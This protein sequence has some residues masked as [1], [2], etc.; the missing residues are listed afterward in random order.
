[1]RRSAARRCSCAD[2]NEM[3]EITIEVMPLRAAGFGIVKRFLVLF[4]DTR[5]RRRARGAHAPPIAGAADGRLRHRKK[6]HGLR[7][8]WAVTRS[9]CSRSSNSSPPPTRNSNPP[10][11]RSSPPTRS[12]RAPTRNCRPPRKSCRVHQRGTR[13]RQR[14]TPGPQRG[15]QPEQRRP[16]QP[17]GQHED[18]HRDARA[19]PAHPPLH[20]RGRQGPG[21][22]PH[23]PG[24]PI[25]QIRPPLG[26]DELETLIAEVISSV[27]VREQEVQD[28]SGH[29]YL[30]AHFHPY[31]TESNR[32]DG[33]ILV[34]LD[35]DE[36][37]RGP[38]N[39]CARPAT[40]PSR[41]WR[42]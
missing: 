23:R 18:A 24:R 17:A 33:A 21:P 12:C 40:M 39:N 11:R 31:R 19:G 20:P 42:P 1:M 4:E 5:P 34:F 35:I 25:T 7:K 28:T 2:G 37:R 8:E 3:R 6:S 22:D 38:A 27:V 26:V 36:A 32:I 13:D 16:D 10:T 29:W 9:T 30:T 41:W 15:D 14:G